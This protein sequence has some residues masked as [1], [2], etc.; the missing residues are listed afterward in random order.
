MTLDAT[1][2]DAGPLARSDDGRDTQSGR[3]LPGNRQGRGNPKARRVARLRATLLRTVT[4]DDVAAAVRALID[5]AKAGDVA[6]IRELLDRCVGK[7]VLPI[8]VEVAVEGDTIL[9][10]PPP[11]VLE[12][13]EEVS[14]RRIVIE[15]EPI[16][17]TPPAGE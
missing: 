6:A 3:F 7:A 12:E 13:S 5:R 15:S 10:I 2:G 14:V 9:R 1:D 16:P 17:A 11:R 8:G 4:P